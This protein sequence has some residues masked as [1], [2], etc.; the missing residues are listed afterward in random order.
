MKRPFK[1]EL[2]ANCAEILLKT[3]LVS[4]PNEG[5]ALLIGKNKVNQLNDEN[6]SC[7]I[8]LI[9]PC[10]NVWELGMEVFSEDG[11]KNNYSSNK[12][13]SKQNR[14]AIDPREQLLAQKW[15]RKKGL[16]I[17]GVAHSHPNCSVKPSRFDIAW[18]FS[19]G[20]MMIVSGSGSIN[21]WWVSKPKLRSH[22]EIPCSS[23]AKTINLIVH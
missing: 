15:V 11:H 8:S 20:L 16:S 1:I 19:P 6:Y 12:I 18:Q 17:L 22:A 3:L 9:W 10:C 13:A 2:K 21:A 23:M 14:F 7:E 4:A 5:C